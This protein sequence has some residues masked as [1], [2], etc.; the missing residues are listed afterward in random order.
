M[1]DNISNMTMRD[2]FALHALNAI[3]TLD[4]RLTDIDDDVKAAYEYADAM[5]IER[6]KIK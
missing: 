5:L 1:N 3:I 2:R 6:L 4:H